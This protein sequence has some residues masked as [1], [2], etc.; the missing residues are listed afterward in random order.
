[1]QTMHNLHAFMVSDK[2]NHLQVFYEI[3]FLKIMFNSYISFQ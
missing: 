1:M 2:R 3:G